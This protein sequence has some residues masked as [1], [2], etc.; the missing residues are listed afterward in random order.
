MIY[1]NDFFLFLKNPF[2]LSRNKVNYHY[3]TLLTSFIVL[4]TVLCL[5]GLLKYTY[6]HINPHNGF[7]IINKQ[8]L[9][10]IHGFIERRGFLVA[11]IIIGVIGPF[12]EELV[13]RLGFSFK[14]LHVYISV[15]SFI[16]Y[17]PYIFSLKPIFLIIAFLLCFP[18]VYLAYKRI[19]QEALNFFKKKYGIIVF[20]TMVF[21]FTILH[22]INISPLDSSLFFEYLI[23]LVPIFACAY[24][25][26]YIRVRSGFIFCVLFHIVFNSITF[27][28]FIS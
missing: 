27:I 2:A 4:I 13:F 8:Y 24:I 18:I 22:L 10:L 11:Y 14:K 6:S 15:L 1:M 21:L 3:I 12:V 19:S 26:S 5:T 23:L 7:R 9:G 25:S 17:I 20:H 28:G 16:V